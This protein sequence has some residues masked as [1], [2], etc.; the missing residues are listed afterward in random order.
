[1][2]KKPALIAAFVM[3]AVIGVLML[4]AG[5][6]ALFPAPVVSASSADP[7]AGASAA[8]EQV[9]QLEARI[10]E[11]Q[12]REQQWQQR[13]DQAQEQINQVSTELG[14]YQQ[15][16]SSLQEMGVLT[17]DNNGQVFVSRG[18]RGFERDHDDD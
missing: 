11:Y 16:V 13:L 15:L 7:A 12:A 14:Q 10:A 6:S 17:I 8:N 4:V 1:M 18:G 2:K 5:G 3:T 9:A